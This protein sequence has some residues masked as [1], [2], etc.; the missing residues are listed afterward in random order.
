ML[1]DLL[2]SFRSVG[3]YEAINDQ[4]HYRGARDYCISA[5]LVIQELRRI[6]IHTGFYD[7]KTP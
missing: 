2:E 3:I 1:L 7:E 4:P 5:T 6:G